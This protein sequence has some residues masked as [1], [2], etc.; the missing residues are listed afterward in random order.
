[1]SVPAIHCEARKAAYRQSKDG[2]VVSFVIHPNDMP[3]ALAVAPLGTRYM[4]ALAQIGDDEQPVPPVGS[5]DR[6]GN[7]RLSGDQPAG[8]TLSR[9][10]QG[11]ERYRNTSDMEKALIRAARLPKDPRF[12]EWA[13]RQIY[14]AG[15]HVGGSISE[16]EATTFIRERCCDGH[17]RNT[18]PEHPEYYDRFMDMETAYLM[19]AGVLAEP[20]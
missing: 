17:S 7:A 15:K 5:Q 10:E 11:K 16:D 3:D 13:T 14:G 18:I 20:R 9:S 1:M 2:L 6:K 12:R 8:G 19:W 4:L